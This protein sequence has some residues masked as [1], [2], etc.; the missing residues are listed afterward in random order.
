MSLKVCFIQC[1]KTS[2]FFLII[3]SYP[4]RQVCFC[5]VRSFHFQQVIS[6]FII[7]C[8]HTNIF[9][10]SHTWKCCECLFEGKVSLSL[11]VRISRQF[12]A[13]CTI[14]HAALA[15]CNTLHVHPM[16]LEHG[17][18]ALTLF[19]LRVPSIAF[20]ISLI[21]CKSHPEQVII[22]LPRSY[23]AAAYNHLTSTNRS[24]ASITFSIHTTINL[25]CTFRVFSKP[26]TFRVPIF[27]DYRHWT[28]LKMLV[29]HILS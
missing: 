6:G 19:H 24:L 15:A 29:L 2:F 22:L 13:A 5:E 10:S 26:A 14:L 3:F 4:A 23:K 11:W 12:S 16:Q 27:C 9:C 21:E 25:H 8:Q 1:L 17:A 20:C 18:H 7:C 28:I